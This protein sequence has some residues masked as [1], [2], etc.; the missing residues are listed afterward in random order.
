MNAMAKLTCLATALMLCACSSI[1]VAP[2]NPTPGGPSPSTK[3]AP[4]SAKPALARPP[5]RPA[6]EDVAY[7]RAMSQRVEQKDLAAVKAIEFA[8]FR[9][10]SMLLSHGGGSAGEGAFR[11]AVASGD[12][13]AVRK[14]ATAVL[15]DDAAHIGAHIVLMNL[16]REASHPAEADLHD[17]CVAGLFHS[18]LAS[19]DGR[20]YGTAFVVYFIREEYDLVRALGGQVQSQSL[21]HQGPRSFD[22]LHVKTK[23]GATRDVYFDITEPFAE[24]AK[25][26]GLPE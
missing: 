25:L 6:A 16:D 2:R 20:G 24:E 3:A 7:Y 19:G 26:F 21:S 4:P 11:S 18:I 14:A 13:A 5:S 17:A 8:R 23:S 15:A 22:I 1:G 9:R 12:L 10:G